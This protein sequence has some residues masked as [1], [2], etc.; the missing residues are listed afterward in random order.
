LYDREAQRRWGG[1]AQLTYYFTNQWFLNAVYGINRAFDISNETDPN[2]PGGYKFATVSPFGDPVEMN[3]HYYLCLYYRPIQALK[4]GLEYT[5]VRTDYYQY[6]TEQSERSDYG[7][8]HRLMFAG[9]F[10]F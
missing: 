8:N 7:D 5:Y 4:F 9:F 1:F 3:Q 2:A 6:T 10:F